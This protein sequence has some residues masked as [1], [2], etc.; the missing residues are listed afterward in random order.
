MASIYF[1]LIIVFTI[2]VF[3][4]LLYNYLYKRQINNS[5]HGKS[6]SLGF[7]EPIHFIFSI[8]FIVLIIFGITTQSKINNLQNTLHNNQN[9]LNSISQSISNMYYDLEQKYNDLVNQN[10][11]ITDSSY[12]RLD[13]T[14]DKQQINVRINFTIKELNPNSQLYLL[15]TNDQDESTW[16]KIE[17]TQQGYL[18]FNKTI[19]LDLDKNYTIHLLSETPTESKQEKIFTIDNKDFYIHRV[20]EDA[21][22][23]D[24][25]LHFN[26]S[27][28]H[29]GNPN[30]KIETVKIRILEPF[31]DENETVIDY[32]DQ[33]T[34]TS[35]SE[36]QFISG[37]YTL[38]NSKEYYITFIL[39]DGYG[40]KLTTDGEFIANR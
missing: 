20:K 38:D 1:L 9:K 29:Q 14:E 4:F 21:R 37:V 26:L 17:L 16:Q 25:K 11:W 10:Q 31:N 15:A 8:L 34:K 33:V 18:T 5:L 23:E 22:I 30:F 27:I 40:I 35:D 19:Q 6:N 7:M 2:I 24:G 13:F 36:Y 12:K 3:A 32:T 39:I 28:R